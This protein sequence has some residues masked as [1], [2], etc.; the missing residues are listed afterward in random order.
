MS[1]LG[2]F[3]SDIASAV[4][5]TLAGAHFSGGT[6]GIAVRQV[7]SARLAERVGSGGSTRKN[8]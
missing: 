3:D 1:V 7:H 8:T 2:E 5:G 6:R 4:R